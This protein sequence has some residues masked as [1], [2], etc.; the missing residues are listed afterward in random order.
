MRVAEARRLLA[1][2]EHALRDVDEPA[3]RAVQERDLDVLALAGLVA[4]AQ[5]GEDRDGRVQ[6]GEHVD[7]RDAD[8]RRRAVGSPVML[9][10]PDSAW[11]TKS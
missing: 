5:R 10:S 7:D 3:E 1:G 4:A 11:M 9:I 2:D 8:L 6:A